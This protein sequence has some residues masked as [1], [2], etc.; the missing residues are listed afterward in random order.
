MFLFV[1]L[2]GGKVA[3]TARKV[4]YL[5]TRKISSFSLLWSAFFQTAALES[6][7]MQAGFRDGVKTFGWEERKSRKTPKQTRKALS[8]RGTTFVGRRF[9]AAFFLAKS[10]NRA[11]EG[12]AEA[13]FGVCVRNITS[14]AS[15]RQLC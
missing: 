15:F 9:N 8:K 4:V 11:A 10:R 1:F 6:A 5:C 13:K 3:E 2:P 14:A 7:K 12:S